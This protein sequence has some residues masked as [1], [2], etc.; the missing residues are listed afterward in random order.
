[1]VEGQD[2]ADA[3]ERVMLGTTTLYDLTTERLGHNSTLK[4]PLAMYKFLRVTIDGPVKPTE[5]ENATAEMTR[6][7]EIVW[8]SLN[9]VPKREEQG[10]NTVFSFAV[11][12]NVPV[13]RVFFDVDPA[14]S[15]FRRRVDVQRND[16]LVL[17]TGELSRIQMIRNGQKV[18][19]E[20]IA[21]TFSS[22][23]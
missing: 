6:E 18:D 9:S 2:N 4:F 17:E 12:G 16:G 10:K 22:V 13:E 21:I 7:Q 1:R 14:Q 15:N 19:V 3:A 8:R 23:G 5:V 20:Q 11:S